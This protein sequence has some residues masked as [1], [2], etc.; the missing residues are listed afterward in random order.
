MDQ[1]HSKGLISE[2]GDYVA[3]PFKKD[4]SLMGLFLTTGV[5]LVFVVIWTT[6]L[7]SIAEAAQ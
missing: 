4:M 5:V 6:I 1:D 3:H 2:L 7:R